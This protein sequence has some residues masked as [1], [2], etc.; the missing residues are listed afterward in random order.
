MADRRTTS[1]GCAAGETVS[2]PAPGPRATRR[3]RSPPAAGD[4]ADAGGG[5]RPTRLDADLG[6]AGRWFVVA[7]AATALAGV[8]AAVARGPDA[9]AARWRPPTATADRIAAGDLDAR[10]P[11]PGPGRPTTS[12]PGWPGRSTPWPRRSQQ[13]R[14]AERDFLLSV[15]H[16]LR[17]PLTS[18][19]GWAEALADGAAP[20][21]AAAGET[22]RAAAARLDRLVRRPARPGPPAGPGLH[23]RPGHRSTCARSRPARSRGSRPELEDSASRWR[24]TCPAGPVVVEGDADRLAQVVA[25]LVD[26][27]GRH[28]DTRL[29]ASTVRGGDGAAALLAVEDDGPGIPAAERPLVFERLHGGARPAARAGTGTGLGLAIVRELARAMG[30][31]AV[32][33]AAPSGGARLVVSL[34]LVVTRRGGRRRDRH[35]RD[36]SAARPAP[37]SSVGGGDRLDRRVGVVAVEDR[38]GPAG[39]GAA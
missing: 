19:G 38:R 11:E 13:A 20:D 21:P 14:Q 9:G 7:G 34:P 39:R 36:R 32:A 5:A 2:V 27:A 29:I 28:A 24:S 22:I 12:W 10:V 8:A 17:T 3:R 23:A 6:A 4:P 18:I 37:V 16:D 33:E 26:N 31:D 30:G 25:N 15:S 35:E 1:P